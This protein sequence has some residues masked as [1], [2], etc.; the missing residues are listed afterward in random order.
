MDKGI[1]ENGMVN[2]TWFSS[3]SVHVFT[4]KYVK[5]IAMHLYSKYPTLL[6]AFTMQKI[7]LQNFLSF[8][9]LA[10]ELKLRWTG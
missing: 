10:E 2:N 8:F 7:Q 3:L 5:S 1:I 6:K 9:F 4:N